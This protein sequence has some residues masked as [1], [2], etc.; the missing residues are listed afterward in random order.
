MKILLITPRFPPECCGVGDFTWRL[1]EAL[2][3]AGREICVLTRPAGGARPPGIRVIEHSLDGWRDLL[4]ARSASRSVGPDVVQLEYSSYGWGRWGFAFWVNALA[5]LLRLDGLRMVLALHE[6]GIN[7]RQHPRRAGV[8]VIQRVHLAL[9]MWTASEVLVNLPHRLRILR[10]WLPGQ[11]H[12]LRYRPNASNIPVAPLPP[13]GRE[14][15]RAR[16]GALQGEIVV[17]VFG[18]FASAKNYEAVIEA[19]KTL[20][21]GQR[22]KLWLLGEWAGAQPA[23]IAGLQAAA[24]ELNGDVFWSGRLP[25]GEISAHLSAADIFVLPQNDGHL[26]RSG[27]F[28][29]AAAHGLPV[30][31]VRNEEN[32]AGFT[33]GKNVWIVAQSRAE[34]FAAA[35]QHL[36]S[37]SGERERLGRN[38]RALYQEQYDWPRVAALSGT[39][40]R[41]ALRPAAVSLEN[42][43][44]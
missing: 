15:L 32:Q 7:F 16:R 31:A 40:D 20:R 8:A 5:L 25:A 14:A 4:S 36:T 18:N 9:L 11:A 17:A 42:V 30:I 26:T 29:A 6:T 34:E 28:M 27:A 37:H 10:R 13:G 43:A 12:K 44:P 23:Y 39:G 19:V 22:L 38:L 1:A 33:H 21:L 2:Q 24:L 41:E 35:I 3:Q